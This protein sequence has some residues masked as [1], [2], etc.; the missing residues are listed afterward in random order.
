[1]VE[2]EIVDMK[3]VEKEIVDIKIDTTLCS[4]YDFTQTY[5]SSGCR[6]SASFF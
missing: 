1:M 2:K 6:I 3:M 4:L 5:N